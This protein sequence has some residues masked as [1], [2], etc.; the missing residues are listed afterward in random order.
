MTTAETNLLWGRRT[1]AKLIE[2]GLRDAVISPGS[3]ST[4]LT[5]A[6]AESNVIES[7]PVLDER[8]AGFFAL[9]LAKVRQLPVAIVCTSGSAVANLFPALVEAKMAGVPLLVLTADRPPELQDCHAGQTIDQQNIFGSYAAL[10]KEISLPAESGVESLEEDLEAAFTSALCEA[11]PVHLNFPFRE[12]LIPE[13]SNIAELKE[14]EPEND[15]YFELRHEA[16]EPAKAVACPHRRVLVIAGASG[17]GLSA[18]FGQDV[19]AFAQRKGWPI[20]ADPLSQLRNTSADGREL[21]VAHYDAILRDDK[22]ARVLQPQAVLQVGA[23]PTSKVLRQR[24]KEWNSPGWIISPLGENFDPLDSD[25]ELLPI[26]PD[27]LEDIFGKSA[28]GEGSYAQAWHRANLTVKQQFEEAFANCDELFEGKVAWLL[29]ACMPAGS[30]LHVAS[31][32]PIRDVEFFWKNSD[33]NHQITANRG[34]NGIDGTLSTALGIAQD[35]PH[36]FLLTGD[37]AFLH[38]SNGLL[39]ASNAHYKGCLT[40]VLI[41][42]NGGGIFENLPIAHHNPPFEE[43]FA[44]PQNINISKLAQAHNI[45]HLLIHNWESLAHQIANPTNHPIRILEI[46]TN[47]KADT[48]TRKKILQLFSQIST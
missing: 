12:P 32:M 18:T 13:L 31:S 3:R 28:K 38:D 4:P 8:S 19:L 22:A 34:A 11:G 48:L 2:L 40:V 6:F 44:T 29:N 7:I 9:G 37:L 33:S 35:A 5:Y 25:R 43:F 36:T 20:L 41:N 30:S 26:F 42:N 45:P 14:A 21:V 47:R 27:A 24:L 23:L 1:V 10:F 17:P 16:K 15:C 39:L 46:L